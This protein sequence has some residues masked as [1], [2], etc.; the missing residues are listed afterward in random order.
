MTESYGPLGRAVPH[1]TT[2]VPL[3]SDPFRDNLVD[4]LLGFVPWRI[5]ELRS[6]SEGEREAIRVMALDLIAHYGDILQYGGKQ[7]EKRR[8]SRVA[9]MSAVALLALQPGGISVLGIHAC[10]EPHDSCPGNE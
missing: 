5:Y 3:R 6:A 2:P 1:E 7:T 4:F 9:L 8:E 10:A